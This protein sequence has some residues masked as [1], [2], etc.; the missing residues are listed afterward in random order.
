MIL[1]QPEAAQ[2]ALSPVPH[3]ELPV[4]SLPQ[5]AAPPR[6]TEHDADSQP[7]TTQKHNDNG[8]PKSLW[9]PF[10]EDPVAFATL[11]LTGVTA[12]LATSTVGLWIVTNRAAKRQSD[13]MQASIK[14]AERTLTELERAYIFPSVADVV[15]VPNESPPTFR[16]RIK[17]NS[18]GRTPAIVKEISV[19]F[20]GDNP[21]V[22][23]PDMSGAIVKSFEWAI[24]N[25]GGITDYFDSPY[26]GQQYFYG[27]VR[28]LDIFGAEHYSRFG[29]MFDPTRDNRTKTG[30]VGGDQY[31]RWD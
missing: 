26:S 31:N 24:A 25:T 19:K 1:I 2:L 7:N 28:Y 30:R 11:L 15:W 21:L 29:V 12:I 13:D 23:N 6:Y 4:P 5:P 17:M 18:F 22:G 3:Y 27:F 14:I 9:E 10:T 20:N 8:P 16:F